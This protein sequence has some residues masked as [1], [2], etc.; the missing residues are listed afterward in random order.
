MSERAFD[1]M[2]A[3]NICNNSIDVS[4][5]AEALIATVMPLALVKLNLLHRLQ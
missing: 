5:R 1:S 2:Q 3:R 4:G